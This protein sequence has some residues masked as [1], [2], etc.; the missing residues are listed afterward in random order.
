[1]QTVVRMV[2]VCMDS[3]PTLFGPT[4]QAFCFQLMQR[5]LGLL[6]L[7]PP[8]ECAT[9]CVN[10]LTFHAEPH[11]HIRAVTHILLILL[12]RGAHPM[13]CDLLCSMTSML[14][15]HQHEAHALIFKGAMS[16]ASGKTILPPNV[17]I[18]CNHVVS[19]VPC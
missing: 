10:N 11:R 2:H 16:L 14:A 18:W 5:L 6:T 7:Q 17:L 3:F 19:L 13:V 12:Y 1:V 4:S 8:V 9:A 15:R